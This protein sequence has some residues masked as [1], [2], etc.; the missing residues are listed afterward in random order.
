MNGLMTP[1]SYSYYFEDV[2]LAIGRHHDH[3][4]RRPEV[5]DISSVRLTHQAPKDRDD[6]EAFKYESTNRRHLQDFNSDRKG[7]K[8]KTIHARGDFGS[9][10]TQK[11]HLQWRR[12]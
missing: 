7:G 11:V 8:Q 2:I 5:G 3:T 9:N 4:T 10:K 12:S 6:L 1:P